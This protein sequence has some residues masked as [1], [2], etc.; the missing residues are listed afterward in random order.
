MAFGS[1]TPVRDRHVIRLP[2][3]LEFFHQD[4]I[5]GADVVVGKLGYIT[6]TEVWSAGVRRGHLTRPRFREPAV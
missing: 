6:L 5:H 4:L 3:Y 2:H 1:K